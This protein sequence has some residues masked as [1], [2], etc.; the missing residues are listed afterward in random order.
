MVIDFDDFDASPE[1]AGPAPHG[2]SYIEAGRPKGRNPQPPAD[3]LAASRMSR[4]EAAL[5]FARFLITSRVV[6]GDVHVSLTGFELNRRKQPQFAVRRFLRERGCMP[7]GEVRDWRG[8]YTM[9]AVPFALVVTDDRSA[10]DVVASIAHDRRLVTHVSRGCLESSR[11]S[12]EHRVLAALMGRALSHDGY[13]P[14]DVPAVVVPRSQA[15]RRLAAEWRELPLVR[16][17]GLLILTI[18]RT[19]QAEWPQSGHFGQIRDF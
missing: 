16:R 9:K 2:M 19:G 12:S 10:A 6:T 1:F 17:S 18:D 14:G 3:R 4:T 5:R 11:S 7:C 13:A 15:Y 8:R